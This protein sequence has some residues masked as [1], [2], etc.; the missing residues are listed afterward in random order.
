[1]N[2]R[3]ALAWTALAIAV[4]AVTYFLVMGDRADLV[5]E[6]W[7]LWVTRRLTSG[8]RLYAD[9]YFVSTPLAAWLSAAFA[10]VGG[11]QLAVLRVLEVAV[12]VIE[13]LVAMS[14]ARWCRLSWSS[15]LLFAGA[16][17]AIGAPSSEWVSVYSSVAVLFALI[18]LRVLLVWLDHRELPDSASTRAWALI[19]VG[20]ACG[21]SFAS[22]PNIGLLALAAAAASIWLNR[23]SGSVP[24]RHSGALSRALA[25]IGSAFAGVVVLMVV[26]IVADG[27]WSAFVSQVFGEKG[28]YLR[29]G[30]SY[31]TIVHNQLDVLGSAVT[32]GERPLS[33]LHAGVVLLPILII[34]VVIWAIARTPGEGRPRVA[35]FGI[36]TAAALLS[37][38]PRPGSNHFAGVAP[39]AFSATLGAVATSTRGRAV[40][41]RLHHVVYALTGVLALA[42]FAV[43]TVHAATG[44]SD[45]L[46]TRSGFA[47]LDGVGVP[48]RFRAG[49]RDI[50][51]FVHDHTAGKVFILREDAGFW[52]LTT[53][54]QN[55]LPFDIPEVSDF[56]ADGEPGVIRRLARGE[57]TWVCV[58]PVAEVGNGDLE[59][60]RIRHWVRQHFEYV[61][62]IRQCDMYRRPEPG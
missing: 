34:V 2:V 29:V 60:R 45:P 14:I 47:H 59:P 16:L 8:D 18:A 13:F 61:T 26:P 44:Y 42:A 55:P 36:F 51:T 39:L 50:H 15:V 57:A 17:F 23:P 52:Y 58:K 1:M 35:L 38:L 56:G 25:F 31:F 5:D 21:L 28:D 48:K 10:L 3:R 32:D 11:V 41:P 37:M 40:S 27:S 7:M 62:S 43:V 54:T 33:I 30:T 22:K 4:F 9:T 6:T 24:E 46:V 19:G 12:F 49:M 53:G 20:V